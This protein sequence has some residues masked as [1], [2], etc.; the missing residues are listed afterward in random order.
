MLYAHKMRDSSL[1]I[2]DRRYEQLVNK[3]AAVLAEIT[4]F[5]LA[6]GLGADS[7][8]DRCQSALVRLAAL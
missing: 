5:G 7:S 3:Q 1:R 6:I 2:L 4:Q 8:P